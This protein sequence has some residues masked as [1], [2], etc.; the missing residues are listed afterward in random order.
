MFE[1]YDTDGSGGID[2]AEYFAATQRSPDYDPSWTKELSD[3]QVP[4]L[5]SCWIFVR[6][7]SARQVDAM[8]TNGDGL[9]S[10]V[11]KLPI[12][13]VTQIRQNCQRCSCQT[14]PIE[15]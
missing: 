1:Y 7:H 15:E 5:E 11:H 6:L 12:A 2:K 8:D 4:S 3:K 10:P 13:A 14:N 9:I